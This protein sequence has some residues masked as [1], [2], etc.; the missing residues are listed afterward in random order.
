M[1][2]I[3]VSLLFVVVLGVLGGCVSV[4]SRVTSPNGDVTTIDGWVPLVVPGYYPYDYGYYP[5]RCYFPPRGY[6]RR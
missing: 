3:F 6:Y 1:K 4:H 5:Q 2:N